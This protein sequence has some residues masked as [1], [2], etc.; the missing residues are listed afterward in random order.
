[1]GFCPNPRISALTS[2]E[3]AIEGFDIDW[4]LAMPNELHL[5]Y[6]TCNDLDVF[7][8]SLD[9]LLT[10][11]EPTA[12]RTPSWRGLPIFLTR[13]HGALDLFVNTASGIRGLADLR[14]KRFA[15][16]IYQMSALIWLRA[17]LRRYFTIGHD[18]IT[19]VIV[20]PA[21]PD[22]AIRWIRETLDREYVQYRIGE[23]W[24]QLLSAGEVDAAFFPSVP[25]NIDDVVGIRR[26]LKP[27]ERRELW[28][29]LRIDTG[30]AAINHLVAL[31]ADLAAA[32][33][34]LAPA[35]TV[36]FER[37]KRISHQRGL[38]SARSVLLF[39]DEDLERQA[40]IFGA[41]PFPTGIEANRASIETFVEELFAEQLITSRRPLEDYL[42][43]VN[44][45][46]D[47]TD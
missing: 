29:Q 9:L 44:V 24:T 38:V 27:Q 20:P 37:A 12:P 31:Q 23:D 36:A 33:P 45:G 7:E 4:Q 21:G 3:V 19:W 16:P 25:N 34:Q 17:I 1:M 26:L 13:T 10:T 39:A 46:C 5:R 41:D 8:L 43:A 14:G 42:L 30:A 15:V 40:A 11:M 28:T 32:Q 22:G 2:A 35:L 6:L 47:P 18:E